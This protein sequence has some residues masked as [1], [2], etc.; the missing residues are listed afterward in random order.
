[1]SSAALGPPS[2][3]VVHPAD[4]GQC[5]AYLRSSY[6]GCD[7]A[8]DGERFDCVCGRVFEHV[9]DEAEGCAW[10]LCAE[11]PPGRPEVSV[12]SP[13]ESRAGL[14]GEGV[15]S[16]SRNRVLAI[17]AAHE[18]ADASG[19]V[20][21]VLEARRPSVRGSPDRPFLEQVYYVARVEQPRV[22]VDGLPSPSLLPPP[23]SGPR[24]VCSVLPHTWTRRARLAS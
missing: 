10:I 2:V 5:D 1:M 21:Y 23:Y 18:A 20:V 14:P 7:Q 4:L 11:S 13:T 17:R 6:P 15:L 3:S 24:L 9:C 22:G 8:R 16:S 19:E 12:D